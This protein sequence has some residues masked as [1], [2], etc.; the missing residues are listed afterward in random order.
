MGPCPIF[1]KR[2]SYSELVKQSKLKIQD[3]ESPE[4]VDHLL[5]KT[6]PYAKTGSQG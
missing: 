5:E 2:W 1:R 3:Y 4:D 6:V